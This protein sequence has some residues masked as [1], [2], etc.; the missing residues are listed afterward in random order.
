MLHYQT[1]LSLAHGLDKHSLV[2]STVDVQA[3]LEH[4]VF[5]LFPWDEVILPA[6]LPPWVRPCP[7]FHWCSSQTPFL[8]LW[9]PT[10]PMIWRGWK[11]FWS[12]NENLKAKPV[13]LI[14]GNGKQK[15]MVFFCLTNICTVLI[16]YSRN[17]T[18][19]NSNSTVLKGLS[20]HLRTGVLRHG[21]T[22]VCSHHLALLLFFLFVL[23][24]RGQPSSA[25]SDHF[26]SPFD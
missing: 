24:F 13:Y 15:Q 18:H 25:F 5:H 22:S 14:H 16:V 3:S 17:M 26:Y 21:R 8:R 11:C 4:P 7:L 10:T 12:K 1:K 9:T 23:N 19:I 20:S 2:A 6:L